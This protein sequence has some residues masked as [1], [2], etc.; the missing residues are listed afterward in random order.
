[1]ERYQH[2]RVIVRSERLKRLEVTGVFELDNPKA[3]LRAISA[4]VNV[5]V[6]RL[7]FLTL[8]G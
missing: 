7:P 8:I 6:T 2:G 5:P 1:L 4:T 3:L